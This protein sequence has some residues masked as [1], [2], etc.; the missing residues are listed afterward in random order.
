MAYRRVGLYLLVTLPALVA[1]PAPRGAGTPAKLPDFELPGEV[2]ALLQIADDAS[3][4]QRALAAARR[5]LAVSPD[6]AQV[7][8]RAARAC[9]WLADAAKDEVRRRFAEEGVGY[10]ERA[11]K[12]APQSGEAHYYLATNLGL[13]AQARGAAALSLV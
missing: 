7:A 5:A 2:P 10:G 9:L 6:D 4:P 8:W 1:C 13:V 12:A 11:V 3:A